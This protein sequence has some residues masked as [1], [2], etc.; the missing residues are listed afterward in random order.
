MQLGLPAKPSP[1][2]GPDPPWPPP[3]PDLR[4]PEKGERSSRVAH[5]PGRAGHQIDEVG[6][7]LQRDP[8]GRGD[9]HADRGLALSPGRGQGPHKPLVLADWRANV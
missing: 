1:K 5:P 9:V 6:G 7:G 8:A 3:G 4:N 2:P